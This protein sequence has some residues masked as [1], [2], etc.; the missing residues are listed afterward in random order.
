MSRIWNVRRVRFDCG[1]CGECVSGVWRVLVV[2][3]WSMEGVS[4]V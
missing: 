4:S 1:S 2:C 3:E